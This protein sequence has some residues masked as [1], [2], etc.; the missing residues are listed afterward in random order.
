MLDHYRKGCVSALL[1]WQITL[2]PELLFRWRSC[3]KDRSRGRKA[4][5]YGVI[6]ASGES[7]LEG[8]TRAEAHRD[9]S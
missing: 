2:E 5:D 8:A 9:G 7:R 3:A 6:D 1:D 4:E